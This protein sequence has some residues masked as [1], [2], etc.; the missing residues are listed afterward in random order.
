MFGKQLFL[1]ILAG[2][3]LAGL[4]ACNTKTDE[5]FKTQEKGKTGGNAE[6]SH[7]NTP[8]PGRPVHPVG[9]LDEVI[10]AILQIARAGDAVITLGAG[11]IGA[12][13]RMLVDALKRQGARH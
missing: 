2:G 8:Y 10:P 11:S 4:S 9:T 1:G 3:M 6:S 12:L 5:A 13:P 7:G